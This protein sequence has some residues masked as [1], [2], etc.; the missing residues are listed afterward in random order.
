MI[1]TKGP[2]K[3][4]TQRLKVQEEQASKIKDQRY[5]RE[6]S[7]ITLRGRLLELEVLIIYVFEERSQ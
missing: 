5:K 3:A 2:S 1:G 7:M 4:I 6:I